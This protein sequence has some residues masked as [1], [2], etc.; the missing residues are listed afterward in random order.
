MSFNDKEIYFLRIVNSPICSPDTEIFS[1][2]RKI[3]SLC[4]ENLV[5]REYHMD[6]YSNRIH[7]D[8]ELTMG[9]DW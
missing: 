3:Y 1:K 6:S 4:M 7:W 5:S 9:F 8:L 2:R